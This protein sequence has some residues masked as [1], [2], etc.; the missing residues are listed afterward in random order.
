MLIHCVNTDTD[1][2]VT[3]GETLAGVI[4][5][6]AVQLPFDPICA[7]V[8]NKTESLHYPIYGPKMVE[9]ISPH[10]ASGERVY[11]RSLCMMLY[12]AVTEVAPG[13]R[14]RV[15]HSIARGY[16]CRLDG[17]EVSES[18]LAG[19]RGAMRSLVDADL[20]FM[21]HEQPTAKVRSL[22]AS[23]GLT[24]KV[25]LLDTLHELYT[26]YYTLGDIADSYNSA[27]APSTGR[28]S[29]FDLVPYKL[30]FL[31]MGPDK[32][33]REVPATPAV[34]EK[35][36]RAFTDSLDFNHIIRVTNAGSLNRAIEEG[37]GAMLINVAE[38]LHE[39][40]I[41]NISDTI[42]HRYRNEGG[43]RIVLIAGPS[44]SGK[45]TFTKRLAI[46]L[47]TNLLEP[48]MISLDDYFVDRYHTPRDEDGELDY[49]SLYA[50]DIDCFNRDLN[51]LLAGEEV[52]LPTYNFELGQRIYKGN[53]IH[54]GRN[55]VLLIEGI[56]GLNPELTAAVA[57]AMKYRIYVSALTTIAI[58]DHN[59]VPTTDNRLLRRIVRDHKYRGISPIDTIRR[60]PS[61]RRGE[62]KWIFPFQE[63]ADAMF[64]SSLLF[65]MSVM[66][67][68]AEHA[69]R[70]VPQDV[71][72]YCEA[73]RLRRFLNYFKPVSADLVPRTSLLREFL[74]GSSFHY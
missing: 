63:N 39:K 16:Y 30:G 71:E 33:N 37:R 6:G 45:T 54:L 65:E 36:Y 72:E 38:A 53:R 43:A 7:R 61:V 60:W 48:Q 59:W 25:E 66:R 44:S 52:E 23:Q 67:E 5:R 26:V 46:Q 35:M 62:E 9:F 31:L 2:E 10:S 70:T 42:T 17:A 18:L 21:R 69:L 58:D 3:G 20:P 50:L 14:L 49:E 47:M 11:T 74:G 27:L 12:K 73:H 4:A 29:V 56:H 15:A 13:A 8:N 41:A 24:D 51:R 28:I 22:F 64:N 1:I 40:M 19:L 55:S 34:Q 68:Q 32:A 57:E